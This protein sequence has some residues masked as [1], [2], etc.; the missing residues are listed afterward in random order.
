[1]DDRCCKVVAVGGERVIPSQSVV[2][3][4]RGRHGCMCVIRHLSRCPIIFSNY[5]LVRR[6]ITG[7]VLKQTGDVR[8]LLPLL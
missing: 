6:T 3:N 5:R 7:T 2:Q 1:M 8:L 4:K